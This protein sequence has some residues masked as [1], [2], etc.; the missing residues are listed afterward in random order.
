MTF[1]EAMAAIRARAPSKGELLA[2]RV[3]IYDWRITDAS[4]EAEEHAY[5]LAKWVRKN[6]TDEELAAIGMVRR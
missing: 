1:D 3:V 4:V 6:G 2:N 5:Q